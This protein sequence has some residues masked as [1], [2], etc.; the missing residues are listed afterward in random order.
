MPSHSQY[1]QTVKDFYNLYSPL[2]H[3]LKI[4]Y[5]EGSIP[6]T[7]AFLTHIFGDQLELGLDYITLLWQ[8]PTQILPILCLISSERN[9]GKTTFLNWLKQIFQDNMTT[10]TNDDFRSR[11]NSDWAHGKLIIAVDEV[12]LEKREDSER[13][14]NLSTAKNFKPESKGKDKAESRFFGKFI[15]CSNNEDN[16][17]VTDDQEIRYWVLKIS[18][19]TSVDSNFEDKLQSELPQFVAYIRERKISCPKRTRMWFTKEQIHTK[20]LDNLIKGTKVNLEKELIVTID[21]LL[22][23]YDLQE[24]KFTTEDLQNLL[25]D[26]LYKTPRN[27]IIEIIK[28]KWG[29][30][31]PNSS[32][33]KYYHSINPGT[34]DWQVSS[35]NAKGRCYTFTR[36]FIDSMLKC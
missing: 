14:K 28:A 36:E 3:D 26:S 9:T 2:S 15:L 24:I 18:T 5:Q 17:I 8:K 10:N 30:K 32:Y 34:N 25:K 35:E 12:L 19:L 23:D 29:L 16:F 20:A 7:L 11:F 22:N 33:Y 31:N 21:E 13:L 1:Q 6:F 4:N 27:K